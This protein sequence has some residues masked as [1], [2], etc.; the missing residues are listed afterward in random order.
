MPVISTSR[1]APDGRA[2]RVA[3]RL[4]PLVVP[5]DRRPQDL[6]GGVEQHE[7]VHLPGE[8]DGRARRPGPSPVVGQH[9][10]GSP[11]PAPSHQRRGS[12]SLHSG[13]GCSNPYSAAAD[14]GDR[15]GLVDEDGLGRRR[16]RVDPDDVT[17]SAVSARRTRSGWLTRF[18][19]SSW[20][21]E[22]GLGSTSPAA[23]RASS[24]ASDSEPSRIAL[25]ERPAPAGV[26]RLDRV[27]RAS[28]AR[29]GPPPRAAPGPACRCRRCGRGTGRVRSM[30]WRRSLASKLKPPVRE[31]ARACRI[32]YSGQRQV[33]DASSG[34]GRCPSRSGG[35]RG[36]RRCCPSSPFAAAYATSWWKLWPASVAWLASMLSRYSPS[37]PLRTRKP[38]TVAES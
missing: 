11:R 14:P 8:P 26:A 28:A 32:S 4:G 3:L 21:P 1:S 36:W 29:A 10:A 27:A 7:P 18:S 2:D 15:A 25:P 19:S 9:G 35:R 20:R 5:Q 12:C 24:D 38:W 33:L 6:A 23:T 30:L 31:P 37:S 34:T 16:R 22:T 13:C 17:P